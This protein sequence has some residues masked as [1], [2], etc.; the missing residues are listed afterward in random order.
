MDRVLAVWWVEESYVRLRSRYIQ[1]FEKC[2]CRLTNDNSLGLLVIALRRLNSDYAAAFFLRSC[3]SFHQSSLRLCLYYAINCLF[4]RSDAAESTVMEKKP[5]KKES[6]DASK[7]DKKKKERKVKA[8][9]L[10]PMAPPSMAPPPMMPLSRAAPALPPRQSPSPGMASTASEDDGDALYLA[11][12]PTRLAPGVPPPPASSNDVGDGVTQDPHELASSSSFIRPVPN[13][14]SATNANS[15]LPPHVPTSA[16][17][18]SAPPSAAAASP[19]TATRTAAGKAL[20][21]SAAAAAPKASELKAAALQAGGLL[22]RTL[23]SNYQTLLAW[24]LEGQGLQWPLW[25]APSEEELANAR[26]STGN[27]PVDEVSDEL[28]ISK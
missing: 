22:A 23:D 5:K 2:E 9:P 10:P 4:T 3:D 25:E 18:T 28:F 11:P 27:G 20:S 12:P 26:M 8:P 24:S 17:A 19:G 16:E 21:S 14:P 15:L 7:G 6:G 1:G 13:Y